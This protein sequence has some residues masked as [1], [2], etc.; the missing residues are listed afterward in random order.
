MDDASPVRPFTVEKG[1]EQAMATRLGW[2]PQHAV[3][4]QRRIRPSGRAGRDGWRSQTFADGVRSVTIVGPLDVGLAGRLWTRVSELVERGCRR[5]I[6]DASAID[7]A[8]D[9]PAL[10]AAVFAGRSASYRAVV[11]APPGCSLGDL[12]P[13]SVGVTLSLTDARRQLATGILHR[14][15]HTRPGPGARIPAAERHALEVRQ[16][17]RWAERAAREGDYERALSWLAMVER[18]EGGL[19]PESQLRR[20]VWRAAWAV[21]VAA[22]P[23]RRRPGRR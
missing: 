1:R 23:R 10:L 21:Q 13:S 19:T 22:D 5:L 8:G 14:E 2:A 4:R 16:S 17:L 18:V 15:T 6:V 12:L 7:P 11:V 20:E 9:E 3:L